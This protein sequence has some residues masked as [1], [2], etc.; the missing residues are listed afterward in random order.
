M[1]KCIDFVQITKIK[2][3]LLLKKIQFL[4]TC[5]FLMGITDGAGFAMANMLFV[6]MTMSKLMMGLLPPGGQVV[7]YDSLRTI[8]MGQVVPRN[9]LWSGWCN[10]FHYGGQVVAYIGLRMLMIDCVV[11]C[12]DLWG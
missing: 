11:L 9:N 3:L 12:N 10:C 5:V 2:E 8:I 6:A 1:N 4:N 7:Y